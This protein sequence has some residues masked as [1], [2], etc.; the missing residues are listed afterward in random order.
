[1]K[2]IHVKFA[3]IEKA[4]DGKFSIIYIPNQRQVLMP[5][6]KYHIIID[7][8]G[9]GKSEPKEVKPT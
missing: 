5:G 4:Q 7:D 1:M 6:K 3:G 2:E 9:Y 8:L